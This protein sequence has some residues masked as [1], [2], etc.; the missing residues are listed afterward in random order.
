VSAAGGE[1][2]D[3]R[4]HAAAIVAPGPTDA[5]LLT[6]GVLAV[7]TSGPIMATIAAP[8]LAVAFWRNALGA[9]AT[10]AY[11]AARRRSDMRDLGRRHLRLTLAAG[12]LLALHFATWV[13]SLRLTSVASATALTC[14]QP[15]WSTVI[16]HFQGRRVRPRVWLGVS[17]ALVGALLLTGLDVSLS[18][19]ALAGDVLALLG[20]MFAAGY[21]ALGEEIRREVSTPA[22]TSICYGTAAALLL[23]ACLVGRQD[24]A[25]YSAKAWL[26]L[27]A[28]TIGAQLL[29]HTLFNRV[30][31]TT[32]ATVVSLVILFE[33]PGA[34]LLASLWLRQN[35]PPLAIPALALLL[36]GLAI[37]VSSRSRGT[38]PVRPAD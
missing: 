28:L 12:T 37:V 27:A 30:V 24:L 26:L 38:P 8:A 23:L 22:Y 13:P 36:G 31:R 25:G 1:P 35:P 18:G 34:A 29:G 19:E 11:V 2:A 9:L 7:S 21:V 14:V 6:V 20:G 15:V 3:Q 32:S 5:A 4:P 33:V 16:T 10:G 17:V